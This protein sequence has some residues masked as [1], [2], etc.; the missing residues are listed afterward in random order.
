MAITKGAVSP[1]RIDDWPMQCCGM[2]LASN[3]HG[4]PM[5]S[6]EN[7]LYDELKR[8]YLPKTDEDW[9]LDFDKIKSAQ[10]T[11]GRNCALISL[12]SDQKTARAQ[13]EKNDFKQIFEF[14]NPNS[15]N[16]VYLY[17]HL[18]YESQADHEAA[19]PQE[20]EED[21]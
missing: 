11:N 10:E 3:F 19:Q 12:S 14:Y 4:V 20:E 8:R 16:M 6:N 2:L 18:L 13:A 15:G 9:K 17:V 7:Y 21:F 5:N 1:V